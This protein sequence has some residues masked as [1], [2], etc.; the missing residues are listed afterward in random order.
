[1]STPK[2]SALFTLAILSACA[3]TP[4][5]ELRVLSGRE[6]AS[7]MRGSVMT[8][9]PPPQQEIVVQQGPEYFCKNGSWRLQTHRVTIPGRYSIAQTSF[10]VQSGDRE[11]RCRE[12]L[13][14]RD[15]RYYT[16]IVNDDAAADASLRE[17]RFSEDEVC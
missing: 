8:S 9:L 1:M 12:L 14:A 17:V 7:T 15:G 2:R 16:R 6:L 13:V 5:A 10:C 11:P 4:T 3:L